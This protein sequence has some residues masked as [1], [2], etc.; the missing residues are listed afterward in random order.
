MKRK[1]VHNNK[2]VFD[3]IKVY[4]GPSGEEKGFY[5]YPPKED[6]DGNS[7]VDVWGYPTAKAMGQFYYDI[8]RQIRKNRDVTSLRFTR[9]SIEDSFSGVVED[10]YDGDLLKIVW[11][12]GLT[13]IPKTYRIQY[14]DVPEGRWCLQEINKISTPENI[15]IAEILLIGREMKSI[16]LI[17]NIMEG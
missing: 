1:V 9:W 5:L 7:L 14:Y 11:M 13:E 16:Q 12:E 10:V 3:L 17:G 8:D 2:P 6:D 15:P 4:I